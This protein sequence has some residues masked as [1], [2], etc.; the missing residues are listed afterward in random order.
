MC[1]IAKR[2]ISKL[3]D[4]DMKSLWD[5]NYGYTAVSSGLILYSFIKSCF[6]ISGSGN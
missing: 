1:K 5:I 3:R 6:S 2:N 4:K